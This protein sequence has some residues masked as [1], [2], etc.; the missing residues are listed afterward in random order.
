MD[1]LMRRIF[2]WAVRLA[3]GLVMLLLMAA[4]RAAAA[5]W[6]GARSRLGRRSAVC[7]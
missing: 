7:D 1:A 6:H 4:G 5:L 2:R 3:A